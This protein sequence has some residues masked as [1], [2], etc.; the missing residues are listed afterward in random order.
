M[1]EVLEWVFTIAII[2]GLVVLVIVVPKIFERDD[3]THMF[4]FGWLDSDWWD[5]N[6]NGNGD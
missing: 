1:R 6:G 4:P 5:G 2:G 3:G